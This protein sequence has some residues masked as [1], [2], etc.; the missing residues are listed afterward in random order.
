MNAFSHTFVYASS[1]SS[2]SVMS[3]EE[4]T[5]NSERRIKVK[6]LVRL[7]KTMPQQVYENNTIKRTR[8]FE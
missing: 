6:I 7:G 1:F 8:A 3:T 5:M 2:R 4:R